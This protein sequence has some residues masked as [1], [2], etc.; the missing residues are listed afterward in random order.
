MGRH[1]TCTITPVHIVQQW[2]Q[3][4]DHQSCVPLQKQTGTSSPAQGLDRLSGNPITLEGSP[5]FLPGFRPSVQCPITHVHIAQQSCQG[6]DRQSGV[7]TTPVHIAVLPGFRPSVRCPSTPVHIAV[8]SGLRPSVP[9]PHCTCTHSS[10][11]RA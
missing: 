11:A 1:H 10:P 9:C 4:S 5:T 2:C 3:G 8:L 7:S 6:L